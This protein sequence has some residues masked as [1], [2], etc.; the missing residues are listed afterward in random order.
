[1]HYSES[2]D[3]KFYIQS[4]SCHSVLCS[5]AKT[6]MC[7]KKQLAAILLANVFFVNI[8]QRSAIKM[9]LKRTY[10]YSVSCS[11]AAKHAVW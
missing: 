6:A 11:Q 10:V 5:L 9:L 8:L 1:M 4:K 2:K 3:I 7:C